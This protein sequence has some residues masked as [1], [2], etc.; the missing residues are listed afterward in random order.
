MLS[1]TFLPLS[2]KKMGDKHQPQRW[3]GKG[4][5]ERERERINYYMVYHWKIHIVSRRI[6]ENLI[7]WY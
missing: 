1:K 2:S 7:K 6:N 5:R 4:Q 3:K